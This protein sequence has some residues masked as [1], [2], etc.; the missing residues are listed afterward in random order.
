MLSAFKDLMTRGSCNSHCVSQFAAFFLDVG[1]EISTVENFQLD[2][3]FKFFQVGR[4]RPRC[5]SGDN[6]PSAGS[7]TETLLRLIPS[8]SESTSTTSRHPGDANPENSSA[9]SIDGSGGRCVQKI[10]TVIS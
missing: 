7:P 6:D 3:V 1:T 4:S 9:H 5:I 10:G 8:L 2:F